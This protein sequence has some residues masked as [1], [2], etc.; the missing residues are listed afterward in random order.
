MRSMLLAYPSSFPVQGLRRFQLFRAAG[1]L[2]RCLQRNKANGGEPL[3]CLT[4]LG[5]ERAVEMKGS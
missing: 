1:P 2:E 4:S 3:C 5:G